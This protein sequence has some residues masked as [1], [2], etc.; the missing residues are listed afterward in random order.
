M[1]R[2]GRF[3]QLLARVVLSSSM[4]SV[5]QIFGCPFYACAFEPIDDDGAPAYWD[6]WW[7]G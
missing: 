6:Y 2:F 1:C 3:G 4:P 7:L 5:L